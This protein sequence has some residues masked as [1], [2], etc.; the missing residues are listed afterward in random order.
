LGASPQVGV[1]RL[2]REAKTI[3]RSV[4]AGIGASVWFIGLLLSYAYIEKG[5]NV[6]L[7]CALVLVVSILAFL[8]CMDL[9]LKGK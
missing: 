8:L 7:G 2:Q 6:L 1:E 3:L 4:S 9:M 5:G